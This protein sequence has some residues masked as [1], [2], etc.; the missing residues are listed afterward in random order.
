MTRAA[1]SQ[2]HGPFQVDEDAALA[3][4]EE[5]WATGG[6]HAFGADHGTWSA[7]SSSGDVLTGQTPDELYRAIRA[8]WLA[9][10]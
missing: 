7:V 9:M 4:L 10:Q 2:R 1:A 5:V 6:Y 8:H 3:A